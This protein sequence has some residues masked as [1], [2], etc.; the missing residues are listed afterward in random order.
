MTKQFNLQ[1]LLALHYVYPLPLN[2]LQR[3]LKEIHSLQNLQFVPIE[4]LAKILGMTENKAQALQTSYLRIISTPIADSYEEHQISAIPYTS[5]LYPKSLLQLID[6]PTVLYA[7]GDVRLLTANKKIACI[8]SRNATNYTITALQ[9]ILPPLIQQEYVIVSGLAK[10]ADTLAH[11]A[12]I[13]YG[14]KTIAVLGHGFFH[15]YP[16]ENKEIATHIAKYHLLLSEYPPYVGPKKWHFPMRNRIISGLS[17]A[18]VVTEAALKSGT[19][20]TTEH[21]LDH[22]KDVFVVPG[23][24]HSEQSKGTNKLLKEGA[25]LIWDGYQILEELQMF[26]IKN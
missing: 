14:G 21:A 4:L 9:T 17:N 20:I 12:T 8:G 19:L 2:K 25:I 7:K 13:H 15:L 24:I 5:E 26:Q 23:P 3:L 10:G 11:R 18:L 22:G 16:K 6:P 1:Q